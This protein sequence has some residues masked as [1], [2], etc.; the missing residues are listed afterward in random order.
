M[1]PPA[2]SSPPA[3][4]VLRARYARRLTSSLKDLAGPVHGRIELPLRVVWLGL[5]AYDLDRPRQRMSLYRTVLTEGQRDDLIAFLSHDLLLAEW[6]DLR[7]LISRHIR[8][9]GRPS[10]ASVLRERRAG[11]TSC[12]RHEVVL[13]IRSGRRLLAAGHPLFPACRRGRIRG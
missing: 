8:A 6:P 2:S 4:D 3:A 11:E 9:P 5:R 1:D 12:P 7:T 10:G 13:R